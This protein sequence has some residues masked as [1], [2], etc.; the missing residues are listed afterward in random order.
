MDINTD[1]VSVSLDPG[2]YSGEN[3]ATEIQTK[4]DALTERLSQVSWENGVFTITS[5][6]SGV[7]HINEEYTFAAAHVGD[8]ASTASALQSLFTAA[9]AEGDEVVG[10]LSSTFLLLLRTIY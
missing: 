9:S 10:F 4:M 6:P 7:V 1:V 3:M 8:A 2:I 5:D